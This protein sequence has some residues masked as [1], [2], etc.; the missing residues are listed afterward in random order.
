M[1][2]ASTSNVPMGLQITKIKLTELTPD[3]NQPRKY[4]NP[5]KLEELKESISSIGITN[6]LLYRIDGDK[7]IIVSG[8]CRY[9][10]AEMLGLTELPAIEVTGEYQ[11]IALAEN[12]Q[13]NSLLPMEE[14]SAIQVLMASTGLK[15]EE[16]AKKL[17]KSPSTISEMLK[18]TD[19]PQDMQDAA[20]TS[21]LWS[22]NKLLKLAKIKDKKKQEAE[23]AKMR[24]TIRK[25]EAAKTG[26][27]G[28][29]N[30]D[31]RKLKAPQPTSKAEKR[32]IALK[33]HVIKVHERVNKILDQTLDKKAKQS[34]EPELKAIIDA[35]QLF[36]SKDSSSK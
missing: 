27:E 16:V 22:R 9:R 6:P 33:A 29:K 19:L 3:P 12:I 7:K 23:F 32:I 31:P 14:A 36:L 1:G 4:F 21:V 20:L 13:R 18:P 34:V 24:D 25:K 35:I 11:S 28:Q 8:E 30:I 17:G 5:A 26:T 2:N 15:Q 10:V